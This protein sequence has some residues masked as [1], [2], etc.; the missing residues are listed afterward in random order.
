MPDDNALLQ[1][2]IRDLAIKVDSLPTRHEIDALNNTVANLKSE[3]S[4]FVLSS[5]FNT[6]REYAAQRLESTSLNIQEKIN[7]VVPRQELETKW[8][9]FEERFDSIEENLEKY[10]KENEVRDEDIEE[11]KRHRTPEWMRNAVASVIAAVISSIATTVIS[12]AIYTA[13]PSIPVNTTTTTI[14]SPANGPQSIS[15]PL[16][17]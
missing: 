16:K 17:R 12:H 8:E 10:D 4:R 6:Y 11:F 9:T 3:F 14:T 2:L 13:N 15:N 7:S 1:Q 5:E